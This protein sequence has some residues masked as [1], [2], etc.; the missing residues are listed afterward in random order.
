M[1]KRSRRSYYNRIEPEIESVRTMIESGIAGQQRVAASS[2]CASCHCQ[3]SQD[4]VYATRPDRLVN[5]RKHLA[6]AQ[7]PLQIQFVTSCAVI[8]ADLYNHVAAS[9]RLPQTS[10]LYLE[11]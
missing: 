10:V 11:A 2:V 6:S 3:H 4:H 1:R 7:C 5:S 9:S 8:L